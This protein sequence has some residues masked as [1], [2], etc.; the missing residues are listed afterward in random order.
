MAKYT[1]QLSDIGVHNGGDLDALTGNDAKLQLFAQAVGVSQLV[2][3]RWR[4]IAGLAG[5]SSGPAPGQL[6]LLVTVGVDSV[7]ALRAAVEKDL[8]QLVSN[9]AAAG[10]HSSVEISAADL[11]R[12]AHARQ[13][14]PTAGA[15]T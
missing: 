8:H 7:R 14:R 2:V 15:R 4:S 5:L 9:L 11:T 13:A 6:D 10:L 1:K 12:W 3:A